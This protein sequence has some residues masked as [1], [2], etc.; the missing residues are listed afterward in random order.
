M[1]WDLALPSLCK[2]R[3]RD[4]TNTVTLLAMER[5]PE[6]LARGGTAVRALKGSPTEGNLLEKRI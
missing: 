2:G 6:K 3:N 5:N 4:D 1:G